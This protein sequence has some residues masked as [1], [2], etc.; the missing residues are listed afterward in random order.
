MA[1]F[2][3]TNTI[4]YQ[5]II[6]GQI[7]IIQNISS[8]ELRDSTKT[9]TNLMGQQLIEAEDTRRSFLQS[10]EILGSL[11][12]PY[13]NSNI[14]I[15]F[16]S[17]LKLIYTDLS[18]A[19]EDEDFIQEFKR[20]FKND[21]IIEI[22]ENDEKKRTKVNTHFLELQIKEAWVMFRDLVKLFKDHEFLAES[23]YG[24]GS[25]TGSDSNLDAEDEE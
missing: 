17:Y 11:L 14:A 1:Q 15:T 22:I 10:I 3:D 5:Q 21:K 23:A 12:S 20:F 16:E 19:I 4:T 7:K 25:G 6:M 8:K 2:N 13:F 18:E 9:I 24:E